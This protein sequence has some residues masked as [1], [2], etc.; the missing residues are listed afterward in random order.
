MRIKS[1]KYLLAL[2]VLTLTI[3]TGIFSVNLAKAD[4]ES[5]PPFV[6]A[7]SAKFG[8]NEQEVETFI[9]EQHADRQ[10]YRMQTFEESLQ[11]AV[12]DGVITSDQMQD[13]LDKHEEM[14]A[15]RLA[16]R[17]EMDDWFESAGINKD[18][19]APYLG[20]HRGRS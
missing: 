8:L 15:A 18:D 2:A 4:D 11:E 7:L 10:A 5:Y 19:L 14:Q 20:H 13:L 9:A 1:K 12:E 3:G 6:E 17:T 16:L